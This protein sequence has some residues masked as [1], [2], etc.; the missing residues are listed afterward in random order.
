MSLE[1]LNLAL[2]VVKPHLHIGRDIVEIDRSITHC[3]D[4]HCTVFT[5]NDN[6][7][8]G[9]IENIHHRHIDVCGIGN[10]SL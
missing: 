6:K 2:V 8:V 4:V 1:E 9:C 3:E 7:A 5:R 10:G